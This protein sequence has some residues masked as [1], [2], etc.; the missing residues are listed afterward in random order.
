MN[1]CPAL[2]NTVIALTMHGDK[3]KQGVTSNLFDHIDTNKDQ[4]KWHVL[5]SEVQWEV[6]KCNVCEIT[7]YTQGKE[8][9]SDYN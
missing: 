8:K 9:V 7:I 2:F 4:L 6:D 5:L 3:F 1:L